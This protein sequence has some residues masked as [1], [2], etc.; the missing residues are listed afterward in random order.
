MIRVASCKFGIAILTAYNAHAGERDEKTVL[1]NLLRRYIDGL[2]EMLTITKSSHREEA[3]RVVSA[4]S[5][6]PTGPPYKSKLYFSILRG[7]SAIAMAC[8]LSL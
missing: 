6:P 3:R 1:V 5:L 4:R 7:N 8:T 2:R